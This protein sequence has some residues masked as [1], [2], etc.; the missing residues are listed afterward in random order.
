MLLG[1]C[2]SVENAPIREVAN[3]EMIPMKMII[4]EPLPMPF[5][6]MRSESHMTRV[7]PAV[8]STMMIAPLTASLPSVG[9][10]APE[11]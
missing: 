9:S 4:E 5:S 7:E 8:M 3:D 10:I 1:S 6:V 2:P 11:L